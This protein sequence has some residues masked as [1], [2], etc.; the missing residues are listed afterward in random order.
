MHDLSVASSLADLVHQECAAQVLVVNRIDLLPY[1]DYGVG[2]ARGHALALN[3]DLRVFEL[4]RRTGEGLDAR[5]AWVAAWTR[6]QA[7][8]GA[9]AG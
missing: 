4:S 3:P 2:R 9:A 7:P 1:V 8:A 5:C 6:G